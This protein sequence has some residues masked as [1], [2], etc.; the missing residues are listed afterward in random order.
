MPPN[1]SPAKLVAILQ[2]WAE[3]AEAIHRRLA[4]IVDAATGQE[5]LWVGCGGGRSVLW[6]A[7][8]F[9]THVQGIDPDGGA[10]DT[11]EETARN[12]GLGQLTSFQPGEMGDLPNEEGVFDLSIADFLSLRS[13]AGDGAELIKE[14]G[15]VARPMSTVAALVPCWLSTPQEADIAAV[16]ALGIHPSLLVE[17][18][19]FFRN[20]GIVELIVEDAAQDGRWIAQGWLG[21]LLRGWRAA[22]WAGVRLVLGRELRVLRRLAQR[23]VMGYSIV[24][25]VRWHPE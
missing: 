12:A 6:W 5:V 16:S 3:V 2:P 21:L 8:R 15:R 10:M 9:D 19:S 13:S 24:K 4:Q 25:G 18:K 11:A 14:L 7:R 23:R 22:G 17:W 20:A 1:I